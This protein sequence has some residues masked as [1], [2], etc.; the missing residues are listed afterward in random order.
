MIF[1][2]NIEKIQNVPMF[3]KYILLPR[4]PLPN[5]IFSPVSRTML[6][7]INRCSNRSVLKA[8]KNVCFCKDLHTRESEYSST[9]VLYRKGKDKIF[10]F[11]KN[12]K[13]KYP[14]REIADEINLA[15]EQDD[16]P[17]Y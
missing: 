16:L 4:D 13:C 11:C 3:F 1:S 5:R 15:L 17:V 14:L 7:K 6:Q 12:E 8:G 9:M 10:L 2:S